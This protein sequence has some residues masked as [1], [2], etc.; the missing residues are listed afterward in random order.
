MVAQFIAEIGVLDREDMDFFAQ[1]FINYQTL[2]KIQDAK[3]KG[4]LKMKLAQWTN[5]AANGKKRAATTGKFS[6]KFLGVWDTVGAL[7]LPGPFK[8][9]PWQEKIFGFNDSLLGDHIERACQALALN[10]TR[11]DFAA[12][13]LSQTDAGRAKNQYVKQ[14]WFSG[15]HADI[16]GGYDFHDLSDVTLFWMVNELDKYLSLDFAYL[17]KQVEAVAPWG[18]QEPHDPTRGIFKLA[19]EVKR[20]LPSRPND[21]VTHEYVHQSVIQQSKPNPAILAL[22]KMYPELLCPLGELE[23]KLQTNWPHDK[24]SK[25]AKNYAAKLKT[26]SFFD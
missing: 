3:Q 20:P 11:Y 15:A 25:Q 18:N 12:N 6:V 19:W 16:G 1:I 17:Q 22:V 26:V 2:G 9:L 4:D 10:E 14:V 23:I 8:Q 5:P 24:N 21:P 13:K 7:G